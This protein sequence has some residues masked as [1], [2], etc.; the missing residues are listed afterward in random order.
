MW[1][2]W[3]TGEVHTGFWCGGLMER[4]HLDDLGVDKNIKIYLKEVGW[5]GKD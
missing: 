1:H 5:G 2:I 4:A 3:G